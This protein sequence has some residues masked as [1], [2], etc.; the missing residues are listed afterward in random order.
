MSSTSDQPVLLRVC[1]PTEY[2]LGYLFVGQLV[3]PTV[4]IE[5]CHCQQNT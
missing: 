2:L 4:M 3:F 1:V 5:H